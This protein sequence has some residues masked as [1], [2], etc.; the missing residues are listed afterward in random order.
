MSQSVIGSDAF[1]VLA[2]AKRTNRESPGSGGKQVAF[3]ASDDLLAQLERAATGLGLDISNLVRMVLRE[4]IHVYLRRV[5][6]IERRRQ[7]SK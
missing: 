7:E 6:E 2:V 4:N 3:R 1:G 5:D